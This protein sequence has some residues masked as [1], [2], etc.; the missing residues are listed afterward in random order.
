ME[1]IIKQPNNIIN[2]KILHNMIQTFISKTNHIRCFIKLILFN[3]D[4]SNYIR[5]Y[6][7]DINPAFLYNLL[8]ILSFILYERKWGQWELTSYFQLIREGFGGKLGLKEW[9]GIGLEGGR[10]SI[11]RIGKSL[12]NVPNPSLYLPSNHTGADSERL[13][14]IQSLTW[15]WNSPISIINSARNSCPLEPDLASFLSPS[16][17]PGL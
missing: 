12:E 4:I 3:D 7:D 8:L 6:R 5:I 16:T 11:R 14:Q 9:H 17:L 2:S 15:R 13:D 1:S 10:E